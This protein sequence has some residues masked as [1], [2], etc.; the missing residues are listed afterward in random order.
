VE[1]AGHASESSLPDTAE[2]D[3]VLSNDGSVALL[4]SKVLRLMED[5]SR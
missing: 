4:H 5:L 2:A 1:G 3:Y